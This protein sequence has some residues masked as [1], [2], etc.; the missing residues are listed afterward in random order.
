MTEFRGWVKL[1]LFLSSYIPLWLAMGVKT[2]SITHTFYDITLPFVA[3][4]F[5]F[6]TVVSGAILWAALSVKKDREPDYEPIRSPRGREDLLTSYLIA[7]IFPFVS[8]D[9]TQ[10]T[11]W[12]I[13][14]IFFSV[15]A[16][17][18]IPSDHLHVNPVLAI[19]GYSILEIEIGENQRG[20]LVAER[21]I[22]LEEDSPTVVELGD[23][24]YLTV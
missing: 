21:D 19:F 14:G 8:L 22:D 1:G 23:N 15:L 3:L 6:L 2:Y 9:Y 17:I 5:V 24:V 10:T 4:V 7:Y 13:F 11:S 20:L 12:L 18:Q 16:A